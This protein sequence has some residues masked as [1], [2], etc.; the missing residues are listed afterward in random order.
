MKHLLGDGLGLRYNVRMR[1]NIPTVR[2]RSLETL[3]KALA[4]RR[5]LIIIRYLKKHRE[6]SVTDIAEVI[7]VSVKSTSKHLLVLSNANLV[8]GKKKGF[9]VFYGIR[10][11][12]KPLAASII[13]Q[14]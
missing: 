11:S 3:F 4:N 6:K 10:S 2:E 5:R 1:R 13:D 14:L 9:Y 7:R 8:S 12:L